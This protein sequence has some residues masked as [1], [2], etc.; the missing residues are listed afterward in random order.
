MQLQTLDGIVSDAHAAPL[1]AALVD[2]SESPLAEFADWTIVCAPSIADAQMNDYSTLKSRKLDSAMRLICDVHVLRKRN[3]QLFESKDWPD[4]VNWLIQTHGI[5]DRSAS[6]SVAV[7]NCISTPSMA[8]S[9]PAFFEKAGQSYVH[10]W[11]FILFACS[12]LTFSNRLLAH[13][14]QFAFFACSNSAFGHFCW[15]FISLSPTLLTI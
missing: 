12:S 10:Y 6:R 2:L 7:R 3:P 14:Q 5:D 9:V 13:S 15:L 1:V 4:K 8:G 11:L